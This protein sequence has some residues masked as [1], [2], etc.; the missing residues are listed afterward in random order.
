M[1][2]A[3]HATSRQSPSAHDRKAARLSLRTVARAGR[4]TV[5]LA[6]ELDLA[7]RPLLDDVLRE[8]ATAPTRAIVL[9]LSAVSFMDS[10]GLH[11]ILAAKAAC[12]ESGCHFLVA[13]AS[14]QVQRLFEVTGVL[15]ELPRW[16]DER[17]RDKAQMHRQMAE[18]GSAEQ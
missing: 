9:D 18:P 1:P 11:G 8:L 6:G 17:P 10:T 12:A 13:R 14:S 5:F 7:S 15:N 2:T 4:V 3:D 16:E